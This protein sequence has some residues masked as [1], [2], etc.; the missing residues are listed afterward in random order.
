MVSVCRL[1]DPVFPPEAF[2]NERRG[3]RAKLEKR[4]CWAPLVRGEDDVS[5]QCCPS[6]EYL[7][8]EHKIK[9]FLFDRSI[10]IAAASVI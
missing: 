7:S 6:A 1:K 8:R 10:E 3:M 5:G 4:E 2:L 9:L